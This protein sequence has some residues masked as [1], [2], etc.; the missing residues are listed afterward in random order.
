MLV[1]CA[2]ALGSLLIKHNTVFLWFALFVWLWGYRRALLR[3]AGVVALWLLSFTPY[4]PDGAERIVQRVLLYSSWSGQ[5]GLQLVL[6]KPVNAALFVAV[7]LLLPLATRRLPLTRAVF[8][9]ACAYFIFAHGMGG[10]QFVILLTL[11]PLAGATWTLFAILAALPVLHPAAQVW[12]YQWRMNGVWL[13]AVAA[14][15][16]GLM[17]RG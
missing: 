11:A 15:S 6:S 10:N 13:V 12:I 5:Y 16:R 17:R 14:L 9:Q 8:V 3:M 7:M 4:L 2:F 1:V